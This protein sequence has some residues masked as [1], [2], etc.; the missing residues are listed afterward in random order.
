MINLKSRDTFLIQN[1]FSGAAVLKSQ[2]PTV[3]PNQKPVE[4]KFVCILKLIKKP[5]RKNNN[6]KNI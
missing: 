1:T 4:T 3:E 5:K 2:D 6:V